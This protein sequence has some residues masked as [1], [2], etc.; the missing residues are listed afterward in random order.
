VACNIATRV[1]FPGTSAFQVKLIVDELM[2]I[3][4]IGVKVLLSVVYDSVTFVVVTNGRSVTVTVTFC[5]TE[6][7]A[8]EV[9]SVRLAFTGLTVS[10]RGCENVSPYCVVPKK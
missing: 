5:P 10:G 1:K 2:T 8:G 9:E 4:V 3:V 6:N 7:D